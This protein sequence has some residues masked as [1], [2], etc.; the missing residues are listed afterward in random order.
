MGRGIPTLL[1]I[2]V[3]SPVLPFL[4]LILFGFPGDTLPNRYG[5][6]PDSVGEDTLPGGLQ[7]T[8]RRLNG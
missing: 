6:P 3:L 5:V 4:P 7:A 2:A 1:I 8:L